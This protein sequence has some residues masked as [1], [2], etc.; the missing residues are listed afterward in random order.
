[1]KK[2][3]HTIVLLLFACSQFVAYAQ[4]NCNS[5]TLYL[6]TGVDHNNVNNLDTIG[7][8]DANWTVLSG[9][10]ASA[11]SFPA[12][13]W[14]LP[15]F[16]GWHYTQPG[17]NW[18]SPFNYSAYGVNNYDTPYVFRYTFC[19]GQQTI[20]NLFL[21]VLCDD[22]AAVYLDGSLVD[23]TNSGYRFYQSTIDTFT[24]TRTLASGTHHLDVRLY[25]VGGIA[26]GLDLTGTI[27]S[28][29][30]LVTDTCCNTR[31]IC[32]GAVFDDHNGDGER[33]NGNGTSP[34]DQGL[35]GWKMALAG[36]GNTYHQNTDIFGNYS[37]INL[38]PGSYVLTTSDP[39]GTPIKTNNVSISKLNVVQQ[40]VPISSSVLGVKAVDAEQAFFSAYPN[41]A[42]T[43]FQMDYFLAQSASVSLRIDNIQG[44]AVT[45][46]L[47][48]ENKTIGQYHQ[49]INIEQL[50]AG[51]YFY[52]LNADRVYKGKFIKK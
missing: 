29:D 49:T 22:L 44:Q 15:Q 19:L 5:G 48:N 51:I 38:N 42:T 21:G 9:P 18:I 31:G 43:Q 41:P 14:V 4:T 16:A 1:M 24:A 52:E 23:S 13:G 36:G 40:N 34:V 33:D 17:S 26:M 2:L 12:P 8:P 39:S 6:N 25:N 7:Q 46:V 20:I 35:S 3:I 32:C 11:L 27:T 28:I 45:Q 37:F 30:S 10:M 50:P 47:K